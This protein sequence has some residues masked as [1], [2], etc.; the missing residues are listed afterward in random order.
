MNKDIVLFHEKAL[1]KNFA[2]SHHISV[3]TKRLFIWDDQYFKRRGYTLKRLVFIYETLCQ[4]QIEIIQGETLELIHLLSPDQIT[5]FFTTDLQIKEILTHLSSLYPVKIIKPDPFVI[6][7]DS[8]DS[9]RFFQYW[10][11]ARKTAF[12][13]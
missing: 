9:V 13:I 4:M 11:Q 3:E 5:T 12:R 10:N 2:G 6:I 7:P 8:D 1:N